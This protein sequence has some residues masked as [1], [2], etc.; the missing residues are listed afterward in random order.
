MAGSQWF[1]IV[2]GHLTPRECGTPERWVSTNLVAHAHGFGHR[3]GCCPCPPMGLPSPISAGSAPTTDWDTDRSLPADGV[4]MKGEPG[5]LLGLVP[6]PTSANRHHRRALSLPIIAI[7]FWSLMGL[8]SRG[9]RL[10]PRPSRIGLCH[11]LSVF[12][13]GFSTS[14]I[15]L[16]RW[17]SDLSGSHQPYGRKRALRAPQ[18]PISDRC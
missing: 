5:N 18:R 9:G 2:A 7:E 4:V 11:Q 8:N 15:H 1:V 6:K 14:V 10:L 12:K 16:E 17:K 3:W 13:V